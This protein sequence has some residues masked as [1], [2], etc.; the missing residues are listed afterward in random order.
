MVMATAPANK[1]VE[2]LIAAP[3]LLRPLCFLGRWLAI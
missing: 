3:S 2:T 1:I